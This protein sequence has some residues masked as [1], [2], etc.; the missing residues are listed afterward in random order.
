M[1]VSYVHRKFGQPTIV[2]DG[3]DADPSTI[4]I[5]HLWCSGDVVG[6]QVNFNAD[7]IIPSKKNKS[8][9]TSWHTVQ[10]SRSLWICWVTI[11]KNLAARYHMQR[12]MLMYSSPNSNELCCRWHNNARRRRHR[13]LGVA[14]LSYSQWLLP[15]APYLQSDKKQTTNK[16]RKWDIYWLQRSLCPEICALLP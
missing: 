1:Y 12:A 6:A 16:I 13:S 9:N 7:M 4:D 15:L 10:T 8:N 5:T 11:Y 3:Y 14:V 2:F